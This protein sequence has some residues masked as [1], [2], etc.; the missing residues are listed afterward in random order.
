MKHHTKY[1]KEHKIVPAYE[2][3]DH[4]I[5]AQALSKQARKTMRMF[6]HIAGIR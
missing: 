5:K 2:S 6:K 3:P 1:N 4:L